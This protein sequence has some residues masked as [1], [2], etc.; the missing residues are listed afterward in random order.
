MTDIFEEV[1]Q[2]LQQEKIEKFWHDHKE[3]IVGALIGILVL[4]AAFTGYQSWNNKRN[5]EETARLITALSANDAEAITTIS[6]DSR[7]GIETIARFAKAGIAMND[8][9]LEL[10]NEQYTA[11]IDSNAPRALEDFARLANSSVDSEEYDL[12]VLKPLL[13]DERSP[14]HWHALLQAATIE[15]EQ[16]NDYAKAIGYLN[17]F[18]TAENVGATL[19]QRADAL[20]HVYTLQQNNTDGEKDNQS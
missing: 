4:T 7:S 15:A 14:W 6:D 9:N 10:A 8:E 19:K 12:K 17:K 3:K 20:R 11:I 2:A 16:N 18:D 1:D 13:A 5:G